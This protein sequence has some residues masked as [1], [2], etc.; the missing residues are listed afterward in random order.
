[1]VYLTDYAGFRQRD[2]IPAYR[3]QGNGHSQFWE[4]GKMKSKILFGLCLCG[5]TILGILCYTQGAIAEE[6]TLNGGGC[7]YWL[8]QWWCW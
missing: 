5:A 4:A 1:M 2:G 6:L 7:F 3:S 8:G